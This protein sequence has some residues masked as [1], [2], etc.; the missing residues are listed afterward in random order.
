MDVLT[1]GR[2]SNPAPL[3]PYL[4]VLHGNF[5]T[6]DLPLDRGISWTNWAGVPA[7]PG[8]CGALGGRVRRRNR[9][10]GAPDSGFGSGNPGDIRT[11]VRPRP[12]LPHPAGRGRA[13]GLRSTVRTGFL[14]RPRARACGGCRRRPPAAWP[15]P[16]PAAGSRSTARSTSAVSTSRRAGGPHRRP[17]R[18]PPKTCPARRLRPVVTCGWRRT[19]C[20][21]GQ[22]LDPAGPSMD[23]GADGRARVQSGPIVSIP[24]HGCSAWQLPDLGGP[25]PGGQAPLE[26]AG[27][28]IQ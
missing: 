19:G 28:G 27:Q 22:S 4:D 18:P 1:G 5:R 15:R 17:R 9:R 16:G 20:H 25:A 2:V 8:G 26:F 14:I 21:R 6:W 24:L 7:L 23:P 11:G 13:A 10:D 12:A 3:F